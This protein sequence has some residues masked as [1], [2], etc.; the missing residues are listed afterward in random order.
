MKKCPVCKLVVA[1][2]GFG[3]FN[4]LLTAFFHLNVVGVLLGDMTRPAK[5]VYG[6]VGVAGLISLI[7]LIKAC[8]CSCSKDSK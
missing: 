2:A 1:L 3:A 4:W 7:S 8:P 5:I 6:L